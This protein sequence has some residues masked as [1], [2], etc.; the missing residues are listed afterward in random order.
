MTRKTIARKIMRTM[1]PITTPVIAP[2]ERS[3]S[4]SPVRG[5]SRFLT[6]SI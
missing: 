6:V 1:Q 4:L 5:K 2:D 3:E